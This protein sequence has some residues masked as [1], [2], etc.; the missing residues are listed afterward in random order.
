MRARDVGYFVEDLAR[1]RDLGSEEGFLWGDPDA[2]VTGVLVTWMTT[3]EAIERAISEGCNLIIT[4]EALTNPYPFRGQ[5]EQCLHWR[6]NQARLSRLAKGD[7]TVYR[8]H[9]TLD[10]YNI[11]DDFGR[12]LG[13]PE[14]Q[15]SEDFVRIYEIE[16]TPVRELARRAA[17]VAG[18]KTIRVCGDIDREAQTVALPWGGL[19]LSLNAA[20]IEKLLAYDPDVLIGGESDEYAMFMILDC[21]VPFIETGHAGSE[22]IGLRAVAD[23]IAAE[24]EDLTVIFHELQRPWRTMT[25]D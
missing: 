25:F 21:D 22:N 1:D 23:D 8:A 3:V 9:G 5:L 18:E 20:F 10:E 17:Q 13:L 7:I 19:G 14:P 16:P 2:E 11:L 24:F 6:S 12:A 4:H 15:I